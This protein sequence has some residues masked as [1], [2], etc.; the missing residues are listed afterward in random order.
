MARV[1]ES[2]VSGIEFTVRNTRYN[3]VRLLNFRARN[4]GRSAT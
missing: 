4:E 3:S 2:P 1:L